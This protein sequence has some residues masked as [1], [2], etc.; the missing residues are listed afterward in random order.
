MKPKPKTMKILAV[1][2]STEACSAALYI[3]GQLSERFEIAPRQHTQLILP[4]IDTLMS[5]AG[6]RPVQLDA[7]AFA[8]GPGSFTGLRLAAGVVQGI[9]LGANLPIAPISTL[10]AMAQRADGLRVCSAIDARL[11][12]IYWG[13]YHRQSDGYVSLQGNERVCAASAITLPDN[14]RYVGVGTAWGVYGELLNEKLGDQ[15]QDA[16]ADVFPAAG[17][18]AE[19]AVRAVEQNQTVSAKGAQPVYLRDDVAQVHKK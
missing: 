17:G 13:V 11:G 15:I 2:T 5:E 8:C 1:D 18:V 3:D 9:G 12:E 6:L 7:L 4:M 14:E 10:A 19:L 16:C